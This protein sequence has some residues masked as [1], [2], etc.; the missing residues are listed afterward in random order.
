MGLELWDPLPRVGLGLRLALFRTF[1]ADISSANE[2]IRRNSVLMRHSNN[3][4]DWLTLQTWGT[5]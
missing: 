3:P 1:D 5:T 2:R 4:V